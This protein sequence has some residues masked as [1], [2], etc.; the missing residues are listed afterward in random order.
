[1]AR[2]APDGR[3]RLIR[4]ALHLFT[5][6]GY[7]S[8]TVVQITTHAGLTKSAF[9]RHFPD[10]REVLFGLQDTIRELFVAG[11]EGAAEATPALDAVRAGL[12]AASDAFPESSRGIAM[13]RRRVIDSVVELR[14]RNALK[15][16]DLA[17]AVT[18]VLR[19]RGETD[20]EACLAAEIGV[21]AF[22]LTHERWTDPAERRSF[23]E[24]AE[25]ALV[26]L[27]QAGANLTGRAS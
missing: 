26:D 1:M 22:R 15:R 16:S 20:P 13:Q 8:T 9:F 19:S 11:V 21:L 3:D 14:E 23:A 10:K 6:Q 25:N 2:W 18:A 17:S 24:L 12:L 4:A 7:D 5:E 27:T